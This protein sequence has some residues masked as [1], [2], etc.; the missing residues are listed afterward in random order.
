MQK[1]TDPWT[2]VPIHFVSNHPSVIGV[3]GDAVNER[4]TEAVTPDID[5]MT[6]ASEIQLIQEEGSI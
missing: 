6:A 1:N 5:H 2:I 4:K 3:Y